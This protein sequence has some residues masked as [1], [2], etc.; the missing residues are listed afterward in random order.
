MNTPASSHIPS[1][2]APS[3]VARRFATLSIVIA[4]LCGGLIG[5]SV[6]SLTC[7][8]GSAE[9]KRTAESFV[10]LVNKV[11]FDASEYSQSAVCGAA[12]SVIGF[13]ATLAMAAGTSVV[14]TLMLRA[15]VEWRQSSTRTRI[16][17]A[18]NTNRK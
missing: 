18:H 13:V 2:Y 11:G 8:G 17:P 10:K 9:D 14:S 4:G 15:S 6:T 12:S 3:R 1:S 16:T 7:N 5:Y